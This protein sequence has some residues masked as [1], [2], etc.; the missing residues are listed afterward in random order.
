[1]TRIVMLQTRRG[2]EDGFSTQQFEKEQTYDVRDNLACHFLAEGWAE[3]ADE[4]YVNIAWLSGQITRT[5]FTDH[6]R[7]Y[8]NRGIVKIVGEVS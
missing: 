2:T 4:T 3:L 1:M 8:I 6:I 5:V 7:D